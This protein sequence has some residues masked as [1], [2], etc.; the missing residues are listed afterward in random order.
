MIHPD[1]AVAVISPRIGLGVVATRAIPRG[2]IVW[3]PD[4]LDRRLEAGAV[5]ALP[6][7]LRRAVERYAYVD[8]AGRRVLA[9][10]HGRYLNHACAPTCVSGGWDFTVAG[11][12]IAAG[13]EL[14]EDYGS[15]VGETFPCGCGAAA[16]RGIVAPVRDAERIAAWDRAFAPAAADLLA[17]AQPLWPLLPAAL[18]AEVAANV[19]AG[20]PPPSIRGQLAAVLDD[21]R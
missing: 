21:S 4:P 12:D 5:A 15:Y 11:R 13:E 18:A 1:T 16:C 20:R 7:L 9:W 14:S 17:V 2:T 8:A 10:D 3:A 6:E 19:R